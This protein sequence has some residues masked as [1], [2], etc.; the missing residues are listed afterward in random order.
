[1]RSKRTLERPCPTRGALAASCLLALALG[2]ACGGEDSATPAPS[3]PSPAKI[4]IPQVEVEEPGYAEVA[5]GR[6]PADYPKDLPTFPGAQ[7]TTSMLIPGGT[8]MVVF[9]ASSPVDEVAAFYAKALPEQGWTVKQTSDDGKRIQAAKDKRSA[10]VS[11]EAGGDGAEIAVVL[12]G[13]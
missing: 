8:G 10:T 9:S 6:L 4:E 7:P 12:G 11:I 1:M 2:L 3:E 5:L 13:A